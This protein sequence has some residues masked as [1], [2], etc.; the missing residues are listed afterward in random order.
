M[1]GVWVWMLLLLILGVAGALRLGLV[2]V[3][4]VIVS[5]K[6]CFIVVW[7]CRFGLAL[8]GFGF[9]YVLLTCVVLVVGLWCLP[10]LRRVL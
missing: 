9:C 10:W 6:V 4:L 5:L 8:P 1:L 7:S 3:C 2:W